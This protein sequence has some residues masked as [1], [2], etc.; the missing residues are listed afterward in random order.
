MVLQHAGGRLRPP[1]PMEKARF[2]HAKTLLERK[3]FEMTVSQVGM[4]IALQKLPMR[5]FNVEVY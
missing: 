5:L 2:G 1:R 3:S 4:I